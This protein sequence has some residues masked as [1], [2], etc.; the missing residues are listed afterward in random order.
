MG[1]YYGPPWKQ[2]NP[3]AINAWRGHRASIKL[4]WIHDDE[5]YEARRREKEDWEAEQE[6][7]ARRA[8]WERQDREKMREDARRQEQQEL[9]RDFA[10]SSALPTCSFTIDSSPP[11]YSHSHEWHDDAPVSTAHTIHDLYGKKVDV[12]HTPYRGQTKLDWFD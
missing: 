7:E 8:E 6:R 5:Y 4:D 2:T 10:R 9:L 12:F 3:L 11:H 1:Y